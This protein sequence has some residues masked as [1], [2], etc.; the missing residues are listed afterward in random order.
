MPGFARVKSTAA[1]HTPKVSPPARTCSSGEVGEYLLAYVD[2]K[3]NSSQAQVA[4]RCPFGVNNMTS[5]LQPVDPTTATGK[6]KEVL[7]GVQQKMGKVP[8]IFKLMANSPSAVQGYLNFAG[9]LA[10]G[11]LSQKLREQIAITVAEVNSCEYCLSAHT[12]IGKAI[13]MTDEELEKARQQ[14]AD[15]PRANAALTFVHLLLLRRG[16]IPDAAFDNLRQAGFSDAEI[17]EIIAVTGL[18]I[19]TNYFNIAAKTELDFPRVKTAFP[20]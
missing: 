20:V 14:N 19:F 15:D 18:N 3:N 4:C 5:R 17:A 10:Q 6:T 1:S 2:F 13:G 12:A 16:D 7:D 11:V 8:N 9:A